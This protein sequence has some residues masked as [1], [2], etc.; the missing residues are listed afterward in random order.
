MPEDHQVHWGRPPTTGDSPMGPNG[1]L[2]L[3]GDG[4]GERV[5]RVR[6]DR[7][8]VAYLVHAVRGRGPVGSLPRL[9]LVLRTV[10]GRGNLS[11]AYRAS[12]S[13]SGPFGEGAQDRSE[14]GNGP[15]LTATLPRAQDRRFGRRK[16]VGSPSPTY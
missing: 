7:T 12:T 4:Q 6:V 9:Y 10:R 15:E 8:S 3:W 2:G 1:V 16:P 11:G 13:C 14:R 5:G